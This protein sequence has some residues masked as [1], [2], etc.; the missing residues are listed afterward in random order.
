MAT[1]T[2]SMKFIPPKFMQYKGN[3]AWRIF[4]YSKNF[5]IYS[6]QTTGWSFLAQTLND[7]LILIAG[8]LASLDL[9]E[10]PQTASSVRST[11]GCASKRDTVL[12]G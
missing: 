9:P 8:I 10:S 12:T 11:R 6:S 3:W 2:A 4:L 7:L 1:C 5:H